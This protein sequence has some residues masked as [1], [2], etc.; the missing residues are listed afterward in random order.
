MENKPGQCAD[1]A[2]GATRYFASMEG[3]SPLCVRTH[4]IPDTEKKNTKKTKHKTP[5]N[6]K[7]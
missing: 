6:T 4:L 1:A 2:Q 5:T 7:K 3:E